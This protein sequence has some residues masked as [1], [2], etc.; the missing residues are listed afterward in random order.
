VRID[1][2]APTASWPRCVEGDL[3]VTAREPDGLVWI[4][5]K[6]RSLVHRV[7]AH[8]AGVVDSLPA[9]PGAFALARAGESM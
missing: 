5:D 1:V 8:P 6:E 9:G 2:G 4:T 3:W 7:R